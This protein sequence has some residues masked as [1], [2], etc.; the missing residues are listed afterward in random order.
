MSFGIAARASSP[1]CAAPAGSASAQ[2]SSASAPENVVFLRFFKVVASLRRRV[3][4]APAR[5]PGE[6]RAPACGLPARRHLLFFHNPGGF[7]EN[8]HASPGSERRILFGDPFWRSLRLWRSLRGPPA[9]AE[10]PVCRSG[11]RPGSHDSRALSF[12]AC[13]GKPPVSAARRPGQRIFELALQN[14]FL[15]IEPY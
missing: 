2:A 8:A 4:F 10:H 14:L 12:D 7:L 5:A 3:R 11:K 6:P 13:C 9:A 15:R 1:S